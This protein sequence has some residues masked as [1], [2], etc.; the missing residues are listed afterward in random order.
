MKRPPNP[1]PKYVAERLA[2]EGLRSL[3]NQRPWYQRNDYLGWICRAKREK[4]QEK[5]LLQMLDE[6]RAGDIYMK[7]TWRPK[8]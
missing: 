7:M 2:T 8:R 4:T 3:Y 1:M 5:R 6:L